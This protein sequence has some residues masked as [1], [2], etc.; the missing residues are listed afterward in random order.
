MAELSN[1]QIVAVWFGEPEEAQHFQFPPATKASSDFSYLATQTLKMAGTD[2]SLDEY[3]GGRPPLDSGVV[4]ISFMLTPADRS[5]VTRERD[6][7]KAM[8]AWGKKRLIIQPYDLSMPRRWCQAVISS[9]DM[10]EDASNNT[11][12]MQP[13]IVNFQVT[14]PFWYDPGSELVWGEFTWG[15]GSVFGGATA[16]AHTSGSTINEITYDGTAPSLLRV[17]VHN[18]GATPLQGLRVQRQFQ[19]EVLDECTFNIEVPVGGYLEINPRQSR[20]WLNDVDV[21]G[22]M[23]HSSAEWLAIEPGLNKVIVTF[24]NG[25]ADVYIGYLRRFY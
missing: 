23:D 22:N 5:A 18:T 21:I 8:A 16:I 12:F 3:G 15:D 7:V 1:M 10:N 2:G 17:A 13:V 14:E 9:V 19:G 4:R 20:V 11:E 6:F 25:T 24:Q